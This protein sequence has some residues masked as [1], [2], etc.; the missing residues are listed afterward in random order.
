MKLIIV[1]GLP[2]S[3]KST[4]CKSNFDCLH[5]EADMFFMQDD[6]YNFNRSRLGIAHSNCLKMATNVLKSGS[7]VVVANT[8]TTTKEMQPY[9]NL[10]RS[11]RA[12]LKV[13]CLKNKYE[14]IHNVP[15][16][17][18]ERMEERFEDY[19][20]EVVIRSEEN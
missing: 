16:E 19:S 12:E 8:F 4:F 18:I 17:V 2:G 11:Y 6:E 15:T 3:G 20:G 1:R 13:Y 7:D 5:V 10:A 9:I 14:S